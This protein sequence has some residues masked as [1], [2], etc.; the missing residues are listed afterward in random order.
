M[1]SPPH[2]LLDYYTDRICAALPTPR[3]AAFEKEIEKW[4]EEQA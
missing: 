1:H 4:S 3:R 2:A